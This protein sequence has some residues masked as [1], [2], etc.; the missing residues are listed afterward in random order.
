M[1]DKKDSKETLQNTIKMK[2]SFHKKD[3][4]VEVKILILHP[5]ETGDK[6]RYIKEVT[7]SANDKT[8]MSAKWGSSVS[9][10]PYLACRY[11]GAV[12]DK[13]VFSWLDTAGNTDKG[14]LTVPK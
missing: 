11:K 1:A 2:A 7:L 9:K 5:M 6:P 13:L 12:G 4:M 8:V 10:N 3:S 14:E